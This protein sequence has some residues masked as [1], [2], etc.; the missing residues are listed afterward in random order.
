MIFPRESIKIYVYTILNIL[1]NE[2]KNTVRAYNSDS[3]F[4]Y[5]VFFYSFYPAVSSMPPDPAGSGESSSA[6]SV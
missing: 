2:Y 1:Y 5:Q 6:E 4:I 3:A